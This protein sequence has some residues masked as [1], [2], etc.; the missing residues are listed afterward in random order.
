MTS[1]C[2][3]SKN[4]SLPVH[5][6]PDLHVKLWDLVLHHLDEK[7]LLT[8]AVVSHGFNKLAILVCLP[9]PEHLREH[10]AHEGD[11]PLLELLEPALEK[12]ELR[13]N[14]EGSIF[15]EE[16]VFLWRGVD[17]RGEANIR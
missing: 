11:F 16:I 15:D 4:K 8:V 7:S 9:N 10:K 12:L 3:S 13:Y 5:F 17:F 6:L 1:M 2:L 14:D